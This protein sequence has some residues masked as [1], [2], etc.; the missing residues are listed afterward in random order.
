VESFDEGPTCTLSMS[1]HDWLALTG[2]RKDPVP[3]VE[4]GSVA[5][6]GD[7]ALA[8]QLVERLAFTI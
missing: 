4:D 6:G 5:L 2:G 1:S 7:E 8:R 3:L